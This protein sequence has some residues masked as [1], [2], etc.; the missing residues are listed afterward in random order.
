MLSK[1]NTV[2]NLY[3]YLSSLTNC[4]ISYVNGTTTQLHK[5]K[6][7][8]Y[9]YSY[10]CL[11][12]EILLLVLHVEYSFWHLCIALLPYIPRLLSQVKINVFWSIIWTVIIFANNMLI[13]PLWSRIIYFVWKNHDLLWI[14]GTQ[15]QSFN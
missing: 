11:F 8:L 9:S 2:F 3:V 14:S 1:F 12:R 13:Y 6:K 4:W 15:I 7:D 5:N 10:P